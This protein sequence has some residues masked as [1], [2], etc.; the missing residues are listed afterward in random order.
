MTSRSDWSAR[1]RVF[2][3]LA[4]EEPDRVPINFAGSC[5]TTVLESSPDGKACTKLYKYLGID[6]Y[7]DPV[8]GPMSNQVLNMDERVMNRFGNDFRVILPSGG[9]AKT[10]R[11]G[12]KTI[13]GMSCGMRVKRMG[14]YDDVF[15]F[16]LKDCTTIK[17]IEDYPYWPSDDDFE[18]LAEGKVEEAKRLKE[19]TEFVIMDD[20]YKPFPVLMYAYLCGYEKWL[21]DMKLDPDFYFALSDRLFEIGLK[22]VE[23]WLGPV[24]EY[25][26]IVGTF[27][28]LGSQNG[29]I[30]SHDDYL[31]F[32]KPYEKRM[33]EHI[34]K[35]TNARIYRHCCGSVYDFIPDLIEIGV[36]ILNP[37]QPLAKNMEPWRLKKEFGKDLV[38]FGGLDIQ[39]LI[40][41]PVD[42]IRHGV[43]ELI[44]TY[45]PGGGYIA[46]TS[47]NIQPDTPP[48]NIVAMHEA[49][50]EFGQYPIH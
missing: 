41:R 20:S 17:E 24:G 23:Y 4:H 40:Y 18:R 42:E 39:H 46:G 43:R 28:D 33:I 9:A 31:R 48:E 37:V 2:A 32:M 49:V 38:F 1:E 35:Y 8:T 6:D 36:D 11:D 22:M 14:F 26:D 13:L 21:M 27:D 25:V 44:R 12:S 10:E 5:Q 19:E 16:P 50:L 3:A 34:K 45:A 30:V 29:P 47:H 15:E 7:D